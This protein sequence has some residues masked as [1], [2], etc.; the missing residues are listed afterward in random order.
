MIIGGIIL[1]CKGVN[2]FDVVLFL[3]VLL[4]KDKKDLEFVCELGVDWFVLFFV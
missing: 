3:V 4:V 2:V 1:N